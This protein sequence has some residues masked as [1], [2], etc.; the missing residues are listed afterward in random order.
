MPEEFP[1]SLDLL[2]QFPPG[3][4]HKFLALDF[5]KNDAVVSAL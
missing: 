2:E 5:S 4:A 1:H 3:H